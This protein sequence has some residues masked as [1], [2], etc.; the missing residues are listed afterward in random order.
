[1]PRRT[2][3][4][5]A[6]TRSAIVVAARAT[7][8]RHGVTRTTMEQ[9]A[10]AAGV[11]RGAVYFHFA[12]KTAVFYAVRD[13]VALPLLDRLNLELLS[14][15]TA[16][17]LARIELF[18]RGLMDALVACPEVR[19]TFEIMTF[20]CEYVD[21]FQGE[22]VAACAMHAEVARALGRAYR[23][24][25]RA[26]LLRVGLSPTLAATSTL[27]F[28]SGL[29]RLWLMD[30]VGGRLLRVRIPALVAAHMAGHRARPPTATPAVARRG[31][32]SSRRRAR[33]A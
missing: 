31:L 25:S 22:L 24:A 8:H 10:E 23:E 17:S 14:R 29:I 28:I 20:K 1:M 12:N 5:S 32:A 13:Q 6:R 18:I 33:Q 26:K 3:E 19:S 11:T 9:I 27:V 16:D 15:E 2:K 30:A 21:E 4:E 7:F